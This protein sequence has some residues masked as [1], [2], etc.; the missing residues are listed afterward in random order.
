[1]QDKSFV[2]VAYFLL[3]RFPNGSSR[4]RGLN[5]VA[6]EHMENDMNNVNKHIDPFTTAEQNKTDIS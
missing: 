4:G 3:R 5:C 2:V 1:M 6:E